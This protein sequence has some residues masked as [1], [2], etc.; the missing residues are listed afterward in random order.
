MK[1]DNSQMGNITDRMFIYD[2]LCIE[3]RVSE[4]IKLYV[5]TVQ[6]NPKISIRLGITLKI[7]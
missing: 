6:L 5:T 1:T 2:C 7:T 3:F 4:L